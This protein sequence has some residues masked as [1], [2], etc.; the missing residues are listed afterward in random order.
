MSRRIVVFT[1]DL[2]FAVRAGIVEIDRAIPDLEWLVL[3]HA[4]SKTPTV[5]ARNQ[6]RNLKRNGWRWIPYQ[7]GEVLRRTSVRALAPASSGAPGPMYAMDDLAARRNVRVRHTGDINGRAAVDE[8]RA[9]A[10]D[11]GISLAAPILREPLF[12]IPREGTLNLHK[13]RL[14]DY[15]GMPPAFWELWNDEKTIGCSVHRVDAGLDT[16]DVVC[17]AT[18]ERERHSTVRGLQ[19][20]LDQVG[21]DLMRQAVVATFR[22]DTAPTPQQSGGASFRK[23]TLRQ[24]RALRSRLAG[25]E[26]AIE[27]LPKRIVKEAAQAVAIGA[28]DAARRLLT[29]P[30]VSVLLYHRVSDDARDNLTVGVEQFDRQMSMLRRHCRILPIEELLELEAIPPSPSPLVCVTFDD[31]YLDNFVNAVPILLRHGIHATFFVST[32]M[33]GTDRPFPHDVRRGNARPPSM[34]WEHVLSMR[35]QGF[36]IGSH[37]VTHIDCAAEAGSVV[38]RELAESITELRSRLK[39]SDVYFAYPF[40]G[41]EHMTPERLELVKR[42]GYAACMSAYG[43][44]N[45]GRLD[46]YNILRGGIHWEFSD[47]AFRVRCMGLR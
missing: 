25:L 33:I 30:R 3:V 11:L 7:A 23:P 29:R 8:V 19:I 32:G 17:A 40:G 26:P 38:A 41:R 44:M 45:T 15:R 6:W 16:G 20:R 14:P 22:G 37:T 4:P 13:G 42:A 1:G 5:L 24:V 34:G 12:S 31:G 36:T 47:R 35:D 28:G 39:L 27:P 43:G 21:I 9:F 2:S 18:I 10:P 46:R